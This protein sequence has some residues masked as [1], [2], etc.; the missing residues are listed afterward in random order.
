MWWNAKQSPGDVW[1]RSS[2]CASP[3][4]ITIHA[5]MHICVFVYVC[6][7]VCLCVKEREDESINC[8]KCSNTNFIIINLYSNSC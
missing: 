4:L 7:C 5:C 2:F 3:A 1:F 8:R 6:M